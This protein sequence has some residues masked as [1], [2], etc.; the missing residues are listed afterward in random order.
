MAFRV[1]R[2]VP[3]ETPLALPIAA[4]VPL[5]VPL[6]IP[7]GPSLA[8]PLAASP[9]TA[10]AQGSTSPQQV[11]IEMWRGVHEH[12]VLSPRGSRVHKLERTTPRGTRLSTEYSSP[13]GDRWEALQKLRLSAAWITAQ[14]RKRRKAGV[15]P[16]RMGPAALRE[17]W[18]EP[19][20]Q[21]EGL[22]PWGFFKRRW[23]PRFGD[24][25]IWDDMEGATAWMDNEED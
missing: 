13:N 23:K 17:R 24:Y 20:E 14:A 21:R 18:V 9:A 11:Q 10:A 22:A 19:V 7:L 25:G 5:A 4:A 6:A 3:L 1:A 12:V 2:A 15:P 16:R 8:T